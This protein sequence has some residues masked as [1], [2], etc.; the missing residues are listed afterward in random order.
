MWR[1]RAGE[2]RTFGDDNMMSAVRKLSLKHAR[3]DNCDAPRLRLRY[4]DKHTQTDRTFAIR[5]PVVRA[6]DRI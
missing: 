6:H 3:S 1:R 4:K 5:L 2:T